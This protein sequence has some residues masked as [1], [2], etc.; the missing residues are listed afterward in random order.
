MDANVL[1]NQLIVHQLKFQQ[2]APDATMHAQKTTTWVAELD[3]TAVLQSYVSN[4][5]ELSRFPSIRR[6]IAH[7]KT[8]V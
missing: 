4:F 5:T 7:C 6:D 8:A 2:T 3:Q 1:N